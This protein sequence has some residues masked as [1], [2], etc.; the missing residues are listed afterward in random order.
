M[1]TTLAFPWPDAT[2]VSGI[3]ARRTPATSGRPGYVMA[4]YDR[5]WGRVAASAKRALGKRW[6]DANVSIADTSAAQAIL[7]EAKRRGAEV[8]VL[9]W[10]GHGAFRRMLMGSVSRSVV[11]G[12]RCSVLVTRR[13]LKGIRRLV[14]GIDGSPNSRRAIDLLAQ[15]EPLRGA[16]AVIVAAVEP[17]SLPSIRLMPSAIQRVLRKEGTDDERERTARAERAL[18]SAAERLRAAGWK[19]RTVV[20]KGAPLAEL[21]SAAADSEADVLVVGARGAGEAVKHAVLGSV[22]EG[23]LDRA[24]LP[25]LIAR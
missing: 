3:V 16:E 13:R 10:R 5:H 23:A 20:R 4:A 6:P 19:T 7:D 18:A 14:V 8:I 12:A 25:V 9:G 17:M 21:L 24:P 1:I 11:R 2:I 22:A 15:L